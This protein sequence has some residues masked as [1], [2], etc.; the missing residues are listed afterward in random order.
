MGDEPPLICSLLQN[1]AYSGLISQEVLLDRLMPSHHGQS[2]LLLIDN[3]PA[4]LPPRAL[5]AQRILPLLPV[6]MQLQQRP[7]V[8]LPQL[9]R[10]G[11]SED[12]GSPQHFGSI[13]LPH[14]R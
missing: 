12:G 7:S 3:F 6:S 4:V 9:C 14:E 1:P 2:T 5:S 13:G 8:L 10:H 11:S